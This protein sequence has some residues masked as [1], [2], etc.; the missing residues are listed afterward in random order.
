MRIGIDAHRL[1]LQR[2]GIGRYIE[3]LLKHMSPL[4][5]P[6]ER[7][8]V[9]VRDA[10]HAES[11][12]LSDQFEI[13]AL[14]SRLDGVLWENL[15]LA[16]R[17]Q[18]IDVLFGPSYTIPL[19]FRGKTVVATHSVNEAEPGA[20]DWRYHLTYRQRNRLCARRADAVV[21][22]VESVLKH[23]IDLYGV[24]P[25][26]IEIVPEGVD[27]AFQPVEDEEVLRQTRIKYLGEDK[28]Y[29][30]FVGKQSMRRS[31]P[32][33]IEA[34]AQLKRANGLP[35]K[36]LLYGKNVENLPLTQLAQDLGVGDDVVQIN[37]K[38]DNHLDIL[39][40]YSAADVYVF[41]SAYEGF[42]LTTCEAMA[43]GLPVVTV[44][45]G[46]VAEIVADAALT[47][48]R[49]T[50]DELAPAIGK[51][52]SDDSLRK[53]LGQRALERVKLFRWSETA[54]GTLDVIRRVGRS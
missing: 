50:A 31:T 46:A 1:S 7:V 40:V 27:D 26:K 20:H 17:S 19:T 8:L 21:V 53:E 49:P 16:R 10:Q 32:A 6:D 4:L 9:Y 48:E 5:E 36:L 34:F 51:V 35:H 15:V 2:F 47:V 41:P 3:Y 54:R 33:L 52:L 44:K 22:P 11:L 29:L 39:P 43:C 13:K 18:E 42:S 25:D 37:E 28:P 23:V 24:A 38:L 14:P 45:R 30:L 12:E